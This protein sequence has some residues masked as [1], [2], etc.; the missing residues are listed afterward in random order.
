MAS[1]DHF[2]TPI[3][4]DDAEGNHHEGWPGP[5][6]LSKFLLEERRKMAASGEPPVVFIMDL[7]VTG[8]YFKNG[9]TWTST[10]GWSEPLEAEPTT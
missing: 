9:W 7:G 1:K 4:W 8:L 5:E 2:W 10:G 6:G 3:A